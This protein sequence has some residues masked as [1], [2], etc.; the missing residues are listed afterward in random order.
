MLRKHLSADALVNI[1]YR[2]EALIS[3]YL[4]N[5]LITVQSK[6]CN[7]GGLKKL[8]SVI[9]WLLVDWEKIQ[10]VIRNK[11]ELVF[12]AVSNADRRYLRPLP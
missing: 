6:R 4:L 11:E 9:T 10:I 7:L 8:S 2:S 1:R 12:S 3:F 5:K